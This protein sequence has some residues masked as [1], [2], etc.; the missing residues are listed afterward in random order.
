MT[1]EEVGERGHP[2]ERQ[3]PGMAWRVTRA[4]Q[5]QAWSSMFSKAWIQAWSS[6]FSQA[7]DVL[8]QVFDRGQVWRCWSLQ[9][10]SCLPAYDQDGVQ[11][12]EQPVHAERLGGSGIQ[13][14]WY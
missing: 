5:I 4:S 1:T 12:W 6:M 8:V 14:W 9:R 11:M 2:T 10:A 13:T 3:H 7:Y